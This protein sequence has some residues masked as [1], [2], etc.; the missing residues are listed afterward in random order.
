[1]EANHVAERGSSSS[2]TSR[3]HLHL[4]QLPTVLPPCIW[5]ALLAFVCHRMVG[6]ATAVS[7]FIN[8]AKARGYRLVGVYECI[9]GANFQ[10]HPSWVYAHRKC[11]APRPGWPA[12]SS[13]EPCPV[14]DWCVHECV[15]V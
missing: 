7:T 1:M 13:A 10:R 3:R 14:S 11:G 12:P 5:C 9:W 15:H 4:T 2:L 6:S 8:G